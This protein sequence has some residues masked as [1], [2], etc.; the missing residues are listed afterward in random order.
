MTFTTEQYNQKDSRKGVSLI[1]LMVAVT[2]MGIIMTAILSSYMT[3]T[4]SAIAMGNYSEMSEKSRYAL[5]VF[6]KDIRMTSAMTSF[7]A[8]SL[9]V[10]ALYGPSDTRTIVYTYDAVNDTLTRTE[11]SV[12]E[13]LL[14]N[15]TSFTFKYYNTADLETSHTLEV[16]KVRITAELSKKILHLTHTHDM[17]SGK[18]MIKN[19]RLT[20]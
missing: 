15:V 1:E 10:T 14:E 9:T 20:N 13:I 12:A 19:H 8:T 5:D 7:N 4:R 17:V 2:L 11:D 16:Q 18:F 3:L 6:S